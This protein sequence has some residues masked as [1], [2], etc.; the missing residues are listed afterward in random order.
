MLAASGRGRGPQDRTCV[1]RHRPVQLLAGR[2]TVPGGQTRT[3][4][5]QKL[6]PAR[7]VAMSPV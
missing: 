2:H 3:P 4:S 5:L 6:K 1:I 7:T